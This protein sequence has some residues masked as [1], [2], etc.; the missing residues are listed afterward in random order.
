MS[1]LNRY[2]VQQYAVNWDSLGLELGLKDY[3]IDIIASDHKND[4]VACCTQMLKK[5]LQI[6]T[7]ATWGKLDDAILRVIRLESTATPERV[8]HKKRG[9]YIATFNSVTVT[10]IYSTCSACKVIRLYSIYI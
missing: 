4:V 1:D 5:W 2:I 7:F 8:V 6:D 10:V 3:H 9:T